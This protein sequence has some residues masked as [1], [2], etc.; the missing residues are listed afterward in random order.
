[1]SKEVLLNTYNITMLLHLFMDKK[2]SKSTSV[3]QHDTV[4]WSSIEV[5]GIL[6]NCHRKYSRI[7]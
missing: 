3:N 7:S 6:H 2:N 4:V 5:W 1:M